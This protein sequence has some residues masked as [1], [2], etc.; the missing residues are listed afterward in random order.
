MSGSIS[1]ISDYGLSS[2]LVLESETIK[3]QLDRVS[4]QSSSGLVSNTYSGLGSGA[5]VSITLNPEIASANAWQSDIDG[6]SAR[7]SA[8]QNVL[9]QLGTIASKFSSSLLSIGTSSDSSIDV[10]ASQA[11]AALQQV[12][13]LLNTQVGNEY[14]FSGQD[15]G[16]PAIPDAANILNSG[17][18]TSI[19]TDVGGLAAKGAA[20]TAAATLADAT[21]NS[22]FDPAIDTALPTVE[23]GQGQRITTG[24]LA[25]Q[26]ADAASAPSTTSTGSYTMD[27]MRS[28]AAIGSLTSS[29]AA[30]GQPFQDLV[31][32]LETSLSGAT[33]G[34]STDAAMLGSRQDELTARKTDLSDTVTALTSQVSDV[35]DVDMAAAA[36]KLSDLQTQLQ[37]SYKI[38]GDMNQFSLVNY[39]TS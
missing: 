30:T 10:I 24:I 16:N 38:L 28:L 31:T 27:L 17:F 15:S 7:I 5:A 6:A 35:Q 34:I 39:M 8:T 26:N 37:A 19:Q 29:Q 25:N 36:T 1:G 12:A 2:R 21:T 4:E 3:Q 9:T 23:T 20:S 13:T 11:R 22:P 18:F 33:S 14:V 32:N